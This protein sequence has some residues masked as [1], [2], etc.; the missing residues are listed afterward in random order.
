MT[1]WTPKVVV[2]K[3]YGVLQVVGSSTSKEGALVVAS[4]AV[5]S[6]SRALS[7]GRLWAVE[8]LLRVDGM[9]REAYLIQKR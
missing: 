7:E 9:Q 5:P 3:E 8:K 1:P 2:V 4:Q 6:I